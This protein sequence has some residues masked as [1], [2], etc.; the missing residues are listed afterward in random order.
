MKIAITGA[1]GFVGHQLIDFLGN[2]GFEVKGV[3]RLLICGGVEGL[4][5][6]IAGSD[7]VIHLAGA[8]IMQRWTKKSR[9][10]IYNSRIVTTWN[11][12]KAINLI[13]PER[14]PRVFISMSASGIYA[15]GK[16]HDEQSLL[17][18]DKFV[19]RVVTDWENASIELDKNI[20]RIILRSGIVLGKDSQLIKNLLP[21]FK[22]G[23]GGRIGNGKQPFP[24]IHID[25]LTEIFYE[26]II[27]EKFSGIYNVVAPEQVTNKIFTRLLSKKLGKPAFFHIPPLLLKILYGNASAM[28]LENPA[29]IP[30]RL[31]EMGF[32]FRYPTLSAALEEITN[33]GQH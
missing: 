31:K 8:P 9:R 7:A 12:T 27:N 13:E 1:H 11:L 16:C 29:V 30:G 2:K 14:K 25:D 33:A 18:N 3:S 26:G 23:L 21:L 20:R 4:V 32:H 22:L 6:S 15:S 28:L 17:L 5:S 24:F 10:I 19:G